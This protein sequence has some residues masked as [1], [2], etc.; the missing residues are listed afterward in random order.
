MTEQVAT[1][2]PRKALQADALL[3]AACH[4]V[5]R[6]GLAG[7][8]LRPLAESL[9]VSVTVLTNRYGAR[10]DVVAAICAA[11]CERDRAWCTGWRKML[12]ALGTVPPAVAADLVETMLEDLVTRERAISTLYLEMLQA[13]AWD[14]SLRSAFAAWEQE[15]RAFWSE[16][17]GRG[18][19]APALID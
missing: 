17:A 4:I 12:S 2:K 10:A 13:C 14:A 6:A 5:G 18:A 15:R 1:K 16:I 8:T 7:L 11:A 3:A 19:L 9:G